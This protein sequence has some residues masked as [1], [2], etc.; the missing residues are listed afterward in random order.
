MFFI[1]IIT[2]KNSENNIKN[3]MKNKISK[4]KIIFLN[5]SNLKNFKN[6]KFDSVVINNKIDDIYVLNDIMDKSNFILYNSDITDN[7]IF[8]EK[9]ENQ[10][11]YGFNSRANVTVSSVTDDNY[12]LYIQGNIDGYNRSTCMQEIRFEKENHN[13]NV[14]DG[15]I[16]TIIDLIYNKN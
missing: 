9:S 10:I 16:T 4:N 3:I 7:N 1:G 13:V 2:D 12:L 6:V 14:Y 11:S 8:S 5:K 15:M